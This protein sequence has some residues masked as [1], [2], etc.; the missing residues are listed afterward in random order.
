MTKGSQGL[1]P[2]LSP[3]FGR[4]AAQLGLRS[5]AKG[6]AAAL[7]VG[8]FLVL[9]L[10]LMVQ[11]QPRP[12]P[13]RFQLEGFRTNQVGG[14]LARIR[15][16]NPT[17]VPIVATGGHFEMET[18]PNSKHIGVL[19]TEALIPPNDSIV[20]SPIVPLS[21]GNWVLVLHRHG[22]SIHRNGVD[23]PYL[24]IKHTLMTVPL[25]LGIRSTLLERAAYAF[26]VFHVERSK[27]FPSVPPAVSSRPQ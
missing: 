22:A 19:F 14:P 10:G 17:D 1:S 15:I 13:L 24:W 16:S 21:P 4:F 26:D 7:A 6:I 5:G 23:G 27:P 20:V 9:F 18:L 25:P 12:S 8:L 11:L 3:R 2:R